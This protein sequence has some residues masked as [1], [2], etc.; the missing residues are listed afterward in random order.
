MG[1]TEREGWEDD[2]L[3]FSCGIASL[4]DFP[5]WIFKPF[6]EWWV[7]LSFIEYLVRW[8]GSGLA[9]I[10]RAVHLIQIFLAREQRNG[11]VPRGPRG[12]KK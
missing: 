5:L 2:S 4:C 6:S 3:N 11:G 1:D 7:T 8:V 10:Y 12:L 9:T